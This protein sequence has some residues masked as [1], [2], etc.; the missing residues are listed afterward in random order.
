LTI[1]GIPTAICGILGINNLLLQN[2]KA[3]SGGIV[4]V[5]GIPVDT[6]KE[7]VGFSQ[8]S[9]GIGV[10]CL[11]GAAV[12]EAIGIPLLIKGDKAKKAYKTWLEE[13][14]LSLRIG[15]SPS[16]TRLDICLRF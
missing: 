5:N 11:I 6:L 9:K 15:I 2:L 4:Y 14:R 13:N 10:V 1:A 7:T 8:Y 16:T 3:D 12:F